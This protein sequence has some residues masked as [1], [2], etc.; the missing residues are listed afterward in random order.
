MIPE[1]IDI[2]Q[3]IKVVGLSFQKSGLPQNY[4]AIGTLWEIYVEKYLYSVK[5][6]VCPIVE[7]GI[8]VCDKIPHDYI[9]GCAVTEIGSLDE[10]WR[11]F[12]IPSGRYVKIA[13]KS[14]MELYQADI[15]AWT[16]ANGYKTIDT[17]CMDVRPIEGNVDMYNLWPI[18]E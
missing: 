1:I 9:A 16:K 3:E 18:S 17:F 14:D 13:V 5:N 4:E 12:I 10:G 7:Y 2:D 11:S 15:T 6:A 8:C